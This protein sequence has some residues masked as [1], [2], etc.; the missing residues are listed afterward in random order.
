MS[1]VEKEKKFKVVEDEFETK[2]GHSTPEGLFTKSKE[3]IVDGLL[4]DANGDE[5]LALKRINFYINRAGDGLSNK[6]AVNAAKKELENK[7]ES[8]NTNK[9]SDL[10]RE[11]FSNSYDS[12]FEA[13]RKPSRNTGLF[14]FD[15]AGVDEAGYLSKRDSIL[16]LMGQDINPAWMMG[17]GKKPAYKL[18]FDDL[19]KWLAVKNVAKEKDESGN[20]KIHMITYLGG[21]GHPGDDSFWDDQG[22]LIT[23]DEFDKALKDPKNEKVIQD[24]EKNNNTL[25]QQRATWDKHEKAF[26]HLMDA[27]YNEYKDEY[28]LKDPM[29]SM[30]QK[31]FIRHSRTKVPNEEWKMF[32]YDLVGH[33]D[34]EILGNNPFSGMPVTA[35]RFKNKKITGSDFNLSPDMYFSNDSGFGFDNALD[36]SSAELQK[37]RDKKYDDM[38]KYYNDMVKAKGIEN[39]KKPMDLIMGK[40]SDKGNAQPNRKDSLGSITSGIKDKEGR[41]NYWLNKY[42]MNDVIGKTITDRSGSQWKIIDAIESGDNVNPVRFK[43]RSTFGDWNLY[44]KPAEVED[45]I[46]SLSE[47]FSNTFGRKQ[48]SAKADT[49]REDLE[50]FLIDNEIPIVFA[51]GVPLVDAYGQEWLIKGFSE[52]PEDPENPL[53]HFTAFT[54]QDG[55]GILKKGSADEKLPRGKSMKPISLRGTKQWIDKTIRDNGGIPSIDYDRI[56]GDPYMSSK[57]KLKDPLPKGQKSK[58]YGNNDIFARAASH[59]VLR[60]S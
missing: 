34:A 14:D 45:M 15:S 60:K 47:A 11:Y 51:R 35:T 57:A 48:K 31:A 40:S 21:E 55:K 50:Q 4:K 19:N 7:I 3:E 32:L 33:E 43:L 23:A 46:K 56:A 5:E 58:N 25:E 42:D 37:M 18:W 8:K 29:D 28:N 24:F 39:V 20:G 2:S 10:L 1:I 44:K 52:N 9:L 6:T 16:E 17:V 53:I 26:E 36:V 12:M 27:F 49:N 30:T 54:Q 13:G 38:L 59:Y 41:I 22:I